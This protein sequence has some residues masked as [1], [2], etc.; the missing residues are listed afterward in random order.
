MD[1]ILIDVLVP[2]AN[3]SFEIYIP[4][5]LKF[6]EIT[7]LVSKIISELSNGLFI[8]NDDSILCEM[9]TGDILNI[10]MSARELELKNGAKLMLL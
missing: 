1:K 3:R 4:L 2:A 9:A 8:S 10:N 6:Y 5:D 7:L